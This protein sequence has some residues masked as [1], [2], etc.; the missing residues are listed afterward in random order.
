MIHFIWKSQRKWILQS[1]RNHGPGPSAGACPTADR[2]RTMA[3]KRGPMSCWTRQSCKACHRGSHIW[4]MFPIV[5][6]W[7]WYFS[8]L[9]TIRTEVHMKTIQTTVVFLCKALTWQQQ[10][11]RPRPLSGLRLKCSGYSQRLAWEHRWVINA[12]HRNAFVVHWL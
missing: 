7:W 11:R 3:K 10:Q 2:S 4:E 6:A 8:R 5:C 1:S 12:D 9:F